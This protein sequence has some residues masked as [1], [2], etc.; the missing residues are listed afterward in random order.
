M[1]S[2]EEYAIKMA[3]L[4]AEMNIRASIY[5]EALREI[6]TAIDA[7]PNQTY[8]DVLRLRYLNAWSWNRIARATHYADSYLYQV[9]RNAVKAVTVPPGAVPVEDRV[10]DALKVRRQS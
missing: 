8:R 7:V 6:E 4:S 10:R 2:V 3:D 1:S 5:A 9:H